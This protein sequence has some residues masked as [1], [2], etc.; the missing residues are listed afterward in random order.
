MTYNKV[1]KSSNEF[2]CEKCDYN[3]SRLSQYDRHL[4]TAKHQLLTYTYNLP[5]KKTQHLH[6]NVEKNINIVKA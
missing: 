5:K 3:T 6:A 2:S 4:L 1:P